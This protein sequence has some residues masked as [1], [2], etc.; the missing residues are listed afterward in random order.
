MLVCFI[1]FVKNYKTDLCTYPNP[2]RPKQLNLCIY[3]NPTQS[4]SPSSA[5]PLGSLLS[6]RL[7]SLFFYKDGNFMYGCKGA[8]T[9][10]TMRTI[11]S[12]INIENCVKG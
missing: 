10:G 7:A 12:N 4:H 6:H 11:L 2:N 9:T 8:I 1:Y 3:F 5:L